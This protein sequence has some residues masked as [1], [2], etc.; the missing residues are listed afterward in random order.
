MVTID[1]YGLYDI[2]GRIVYKDG[3]VSYNWSKF[4]LYKWIPL[5]IMESAFDN[6]WKVLIDDIIK[7]WVKWEWRSKEKIRV[8][9]KP[10]NRKMRSEF[11]LALDQPPIA[12]KSDYIILSPVFSFNN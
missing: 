10:F 8:C 9:I 12:I 4:D 1:K 6:E 7:K 2:K 5:D 11:K 3:A